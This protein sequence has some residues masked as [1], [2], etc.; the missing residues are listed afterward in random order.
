MGFILTVM[1]LVIVRL[2]CQFER[3]LN[4]VRTVYLLFHTRLLFFRGLSCFTWSVHAA[5]A[6][7]VVRLFFIP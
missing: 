1:S 3:G 2:N 6:A 4:F 5:S 7:G